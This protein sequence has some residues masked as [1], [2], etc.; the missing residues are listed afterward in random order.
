MCKYRGC[1]SNSLDQALKISIL[2]QKLAF[3][4]FR[5]TDCDRPVIFC[6]PK[7]EREREREREIVSE[8]ER[9]GRE[10]RNNYIKDVQ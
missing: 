10:K 2:C 3:Y 1:C 7:R 6:V 5:F 8:R 4:W 9:W